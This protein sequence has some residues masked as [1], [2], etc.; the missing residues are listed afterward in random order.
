MRLWRVEVGNIIE[1]TAD[2]L[3]MIIVSGRQAEIPVAEADSFPEDLV[4]QT[5]A[6]T[7]SLAR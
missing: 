6:I 7:D 2:Y 4:S 3:L 1:R 5:L